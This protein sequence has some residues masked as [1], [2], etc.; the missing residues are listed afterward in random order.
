[1]AIGEAHRFADVG[2]IPLVNVSFQL[3]L[4]LI[5]FSRWSLLTN[6]RL[7]KSWAVFQFEYDLLTFDQRN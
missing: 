6:L 3:C 5:S 4:C 7:I 1:M 2:A